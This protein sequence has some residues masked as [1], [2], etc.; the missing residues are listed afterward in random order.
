MVLITF[1]ATYPFS[2]VIKFICNNNPIRGRCKVRLLDIN[3]YFTSTPAYVGY[4]RLDSPDGQLRNNKCS[5]IN[6]GGIIITPHLSN[7]PFDRDIICQDK[8]FEFE[9]E[10]STTNLVL[11]LIPATNPPD[12][13]N[14]ITQFD[15]GWLVLDVI[16]LQN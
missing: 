10:L 11:N 14:N 1:R 16:P 15:S 8:A 7:I 4:F 12:S 3:M 6:Y 13:V 2:G 5:G 9:T